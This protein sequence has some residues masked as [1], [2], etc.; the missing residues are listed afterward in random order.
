MYSG[1]LKAAEQQCNRMIACAELRKT[2]ERP[3]DIPAGD[4]EL[5]YRACRGMFLGAQAIERAIYLKEVIQKTMGVTC[6]KENIPELRAVE[7]EI[8]ARGEGGEHELR[9]ARPLAERCFS[10]LRCVLT[11]MR[12]CVAART[13][14]RPPP[15]R[16]MTRTRGRSRRGG[17]CARTSSGR[18]W[19]TAS[20]TSTRALPA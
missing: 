14:G 10:S 4:A 1:E 11:P 3:E 17:R 2:Y 5:L 13:A 6:R 15:A 19:R 7:A 20:R 12:C 18:P 8:E 16:E 9:W